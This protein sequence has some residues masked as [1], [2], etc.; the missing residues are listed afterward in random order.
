MTTRF[1]NDASCLMGLSGKRDAEGKIFV[2]SRF[3]SQWEGRANST[4]MECPKKRRIWSFISLDG[5][6]KQRRSTQS[7]SRDS[8]VWNGDV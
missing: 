3:S 4:K 8:P 5:A 1:R 7:V 2:E 6:T